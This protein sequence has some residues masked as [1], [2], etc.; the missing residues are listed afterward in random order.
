MGVVLSY[1]TFPVL[2]ARQRGVVITQYPMY[3]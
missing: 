2:A 3:Y 1:N